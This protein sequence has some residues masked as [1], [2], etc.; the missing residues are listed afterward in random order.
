MEGRT[1]TAAFH[2]LIAAVIDRAIDDLKGTGL[3][4]GRKDTDRAMAF[5]LSDVCEGY[6]LELGIDCEV[7]REKAAALYRKII[8]KEAPEAGRK[9]RPGRPLKVIRHGNARQ[10]PGERRIVTGR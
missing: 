1:V 7:I 6:C 9:K 2:S 4:C 10:R 5:I 8:R 3:R